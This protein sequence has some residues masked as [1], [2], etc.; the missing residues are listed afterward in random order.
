MGALSATTLDPQDRIKRLRQ[1]LDGEDKKQ[2]KNILAA[3]TMYEEGILPA[4]TSV[5]IQEGKAV[6]IEMI[7]LGKPW[8]I[9]TSGADLDFFVLFSSLSGVVGQPGQANYAS[10]NT[11]LD[12]FAQYR[13]GLGLA[14][15]VVDIGA[16]EGIGIISRSE[17]RSGFR[18]ISEQQV[19]D[20]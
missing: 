20:S 10:A 15:S 13:N 16:V 5:F 18:P 12:A 6:A 8:W 19:L 2:K 1:L 4:S 11:F 7:N 17:S 3:I 9:D 14:A